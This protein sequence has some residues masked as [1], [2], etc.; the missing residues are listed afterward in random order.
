MSE[1][2]RRVSSGSPYEATIGFSRAVRIGDR[3]VVSGTAPIMPD[4]SVDPDPAAQAHRCFEIVARALA[5]AGASVADVVR[6]RI[7]LVDRGDATAIGTVHG[8]VFGDVRPASTMIVVAG[9]LDPR[10]KV[11]VEV[12]AIVP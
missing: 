7:Y 1:D 6:T 2:R 4:G 3:V 9:L 5:E 8:T 10:W 12:E 11:E